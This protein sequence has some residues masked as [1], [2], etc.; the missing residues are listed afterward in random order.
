[1]STQVQIRR[2][3]TAEHQTFVGAEGELTIDTEKK[4]ILVHD[5][6]TVGGNAVGTPPAQAFFFASM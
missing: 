1:M 4:T 3:T 2:G 5:G 6:V